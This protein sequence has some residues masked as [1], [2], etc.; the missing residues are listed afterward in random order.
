MSDMGTIFRQAEASA[1]SLPDFGH[2]YPPS[3]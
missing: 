1:T 2:G 3:G